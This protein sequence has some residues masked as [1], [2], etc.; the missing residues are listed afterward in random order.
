LISIIQKCKIWELEQPLAL[1]YVL[2]L[3]KSY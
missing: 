3:D 2:Y 1:A